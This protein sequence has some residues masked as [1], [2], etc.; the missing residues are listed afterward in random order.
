MKTT[1]GL[2]LAASGIL[3]LIGKTVADLSLVEEIGQSTFIH[4]RSSKCSLLKSLRKRVG[5]I[6]SRSLMI[7]TDDLSLRDT[8]FDGCAEYLTFDALFKKIFQRIAKEHSIGGDV[9]DT[10]NRY[11]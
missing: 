9:F 6:R 10:L 5:Q 2:I 1:V 4:G 7:E 3:S 11:S 8:L